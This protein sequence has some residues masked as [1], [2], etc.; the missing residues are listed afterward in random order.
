MTPMEQIVFREAA[1]RPDNPPR[2]S[3]GEVHLWSARVDL[4]APRVEQLYA[5]LDPSERQR[6]SR[7]HF[8]RHRR[9]HV[10]RT[11]LLRSLLGGYLARPPQSI[12]FRFG[13]KG[14]PALAESEEP[15][16]RFNLS[17]S[18]EVAVF[19]FTTDC[20]LGVDVEFLRPMPDAEEVA[21]RFFSRSEVAM[22][23]T[24]GKS[25]RE[26]AFF[27]CWT[28]KEAYIKAIG[29]GLSKPLDQFA[30]SLIPGDAPRFLSVDGDQAEAHRWTLHHFEPCEGY[31]GALA[32]RGQGLR[33]SARTIGPSS[34]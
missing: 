22:L 9:R 34:P 15:K 2:L 21:T 20:S 27:N 5:L 24:V 29:D 13:E 18:E 10:V 31:L 16:L 4:D 11:A 6:A 32:F 7:F 19:A 30:V 33:I 3:P 23:E 25:Q 12:R 1:D 26:L 28:R 14:K 17:H 8:E